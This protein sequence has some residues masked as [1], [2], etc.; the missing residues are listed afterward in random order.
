MRALPCLVLAGCFAPDVIAGQPCAP[1]GW[2]PE[3]LEC[4]SDRVCREHP[5]TDTPPTFAYAFVTSTTVALASLGSPEAADALCE[6]AAASA[7]LDGHYIAW[8]SSASRNVGDLLR[9]T[10]FGWLRTDGRLFADSLASLQ[11]GRIAYP[12]R[13]DERHMPVADGTLVMTVTGPQGRFSVGSA[14]CFVPSSL[15]MAATGYVDGGTGQWTEHGFDLRCNQPTPLYCFGLDAVAPAPVV[16]HP[17]TRAFLSSAQPN[18]SNGRGFLDTQCRID[19]MTANLPNAATFVAFIPTSTQTMVARLGTGPWARPDGVTFL[20]ADHSVLAPLDVT[21]KL[22][23]VDAQVWG[24]TMRI[25]QLAALSE[26]CNDWD[27]TGSDALVGR[28]SRASAA[29]MVDEDGF[30]SA[31]FTNHNVYCIDP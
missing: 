26:N 18:G 12:L 10:T 4:Q 8:V 22:E 24:G 9:T 3:P 21:S 14:D 28:A 17:A 13:V 31:C 23:Y 19:A 6:S 2:C 27:S 25:D 7:S 30:T 29:A 20:A 15:T 11:A 16:E 1:D 5:S